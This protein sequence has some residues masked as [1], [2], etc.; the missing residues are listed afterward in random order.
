MTKPLDDYDSPWK[1]VLE[2]YFQDF[3]AFFFPEA[4]ADIDWSRGYRWLDTEL[5]QVVRDAKLGRRF[6][7]KLVEVQRHDG[8]PTLVS[9]HIEVQS[10]YEAGLPSA[11]SSTTTGCTTGFGDR[12]SALQF[13]ATTAQPGSRRDTAMACGS[14]NWIFGS[15]SSSSW[16]TH[17]S[18]R[19]WRR[20]PTRSPRSCW[21]VALAQQLIQQ[22]GGWRGLQ[23][24]T[25]EELQRMPG[26]GRTSAAQIKAALEVT[27]RVMLAQPGERLQIKSP[28]DAA[29]LL[30]IEMSHLDQE[31]LRVML[32]DT[33]N[34]VQ[35]LHTV[36]RGS[37]NASMVR[38]GEVFKEAV[39]L[40]SAAIIVA[41]QHPSGDPTPSPEDVL[42]TR[43]IVSAGKL[44]DID[45][46]DHLVIGHGRFV[47][48]RE[49]GLGFSK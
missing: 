49:C 9:I 3:M 43:E 10:Q 2:R 13:L 30:M 7:D 6:A 27:R 48:M 46:L 44:L 37:L 41:H 23:Q 14:A 4:H 25:L 16:T 45:T 24:A 36:Y 28:T 26:L 21:P 31:E 47:S 18:R 34:R 33:K 19:N 32:L 29:Q 12:S 1:D 38:V 15:Q 11:C 40:N 5:R 8:E 20:T 22:F 17:R 35:K 42:V 39:R